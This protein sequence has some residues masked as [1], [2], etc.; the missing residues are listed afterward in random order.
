MD[1]QN[2][3]QKHRRHLKLSI[4]TLSLGLLTFG[5]ATFWPNPERPK[6]S[7]EYSSLQRIISLENT[8]QELGDILGD[9][10]NEVSLKLEDVI[11]A[12]QKRITEIEKT[13]E[14]QVYQENYKKLKAKKN[15]IGLFGGVGLYLVG[16]VG[17]MRGMNRYYREKSKIQPGK[18]S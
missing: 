16:V 9:E 15:C 13:P 3:I 8:K 2:Q 4:A 7:R 11:Y 1:L 5:V 12:G 18:E 17:L 10:G 6:I 14:F